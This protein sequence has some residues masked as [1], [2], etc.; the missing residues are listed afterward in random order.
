LIKLNADSILA[1]QE[2]IGDFAEI[3]TTQIRAL[4][5]ATTQA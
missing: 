2:V 4:F 1:I 5:G 3:T